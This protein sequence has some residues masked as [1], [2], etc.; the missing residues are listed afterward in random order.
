MKELELYQPVAFDHTSG[1]LR[2]THKAFGP[3]A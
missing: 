2:R 1:S 3:T